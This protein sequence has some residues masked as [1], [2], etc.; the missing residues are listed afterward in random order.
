[1][2]NQ[3]GGVP[4]ASAADTRDCLPFEAM[5]PDAIDGTLGAEQQAQFDEH[6]AGCASCQAMLADARRGMAWLEML[7]VSA[8]EPPAGL[9]ERI[10]AKTSVERAREEEAARAERR[11]ASEAALLLGRPVA[12]TA[13]VEASS[14]PS[15]RVLPFRSRLQT[16]LHAARMTVLQPRFAMTAAMAF[17]SIALTLN[18]SGVRVSEFR[19]SD[20][21]PASVKRGVYDTRA[22]VVRYYANLRVV[23]ELESRVR[24]LQRSNDNGTQEPAAVTTPQAAPAAP[25]AEKKPE[26]TPKKPGAK[27]NPGTSRWEGPSRPDKLAGPA[28]P[29]PRQTPAAV[30]AVSLKHAAM[31]FQGRGSV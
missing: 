31:R 6:M 27:A 11:A 15:G 21:R 4:G 19:L 25:P 20:L 24:D 13:P 30:V 10:L 8:P 16:R 1:M 23:Y 26:P 7:R 2:I 12:A 18:L 3:F 14:A 17:F 5:L 29:M 22:R 28:E 9:V